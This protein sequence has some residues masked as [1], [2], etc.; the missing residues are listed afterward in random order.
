MN[1]TAIRE[2]TQG[3]IARHIRGRRPGVLG[4]VASRVLLAVAWA[5]LLLGLGIL[6]TRLAGY[7]FISTRG[8]SMEPA[9]YAGSLVV[10]G[11]TAPED[12]WIGDIIAFPGTSKGAP[13]IVHRVVALMEDGHRIVAIT[14]GD[15]NPVP[16]PEPLILDGTVAR[17]VLGIPYVGWWLTPTLG[18][19]LLGAAALLGLSL[20]HRRMSKGRTATVRMTHSQ[21]DYWT[22]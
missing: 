14:R 4:K 10:T 7:Q 12:I 16:D 18:W 1:I 9:L 19:H 2:T 5:L 3:G 22:V 15:N 11:R 6:G 17:V 8:D 21:R 13:N 20:A